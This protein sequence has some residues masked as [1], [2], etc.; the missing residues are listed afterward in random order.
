MLEVECWTFSSL[1]VRVAHYAFGCSWRFSR[2]PNCHR[3]LSGPSLAR[4]ARFLERRLRIVDLAGVRGCGAELERMA[5]AAA[6]SVLLGVQQSRRR[7]SIRNL[8]NFYKRGR[9]SDLEISAH[10]STTG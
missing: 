4:S 10:V 1:D 5:S 7:I 3:F 9:R 2:R 6:Q 8:F